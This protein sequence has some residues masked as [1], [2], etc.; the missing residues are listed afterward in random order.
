MKIKNN[1]IH[2]SILS[3]TSIIALI[4]SNIITILFAIFDQ[5]DL[6]TIMFIYWCQSI[7]IGFF[8][9]IKIL[10]LKDNT[11]QNFTVNG[12][13]AKLT[14]KTK[15]FMAIFFSMHYGMFHLGYL[16]F[17]LS[18]PFT[19]NPLQVRQPINIVFIL[20]L[21]FINHLYSL[22]Y[23]LKKDQKKIK[24]IG[25]LFFYPYFRI[26]P[27]HLTIIFG[28]FFL[29]IFGMQSEQ[30]IILFFLLLKTIADVKMHSKE[31]NI[32]KYIK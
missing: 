4:L 25:K 32:E 8:N 26:I 27:M 11:T 29:I 20:I 15:L 5:W 16:V 23:N 2:L 3:D 12:K 24:N 31:H 22:V 19:S 17:I 7:I 9:V 21:F 6:T 14:I 13:P 18:N 28:G 10:I 1:I 30:Y